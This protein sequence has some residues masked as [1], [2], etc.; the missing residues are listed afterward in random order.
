MWHGLNRLSCWRV[1]WIH[2]Q[3][4]LVWPASHQNV[5][6]LRI[7]IDLTDHAEGFSVDLDQCS[8]FMGG[9]VAPGAEQ[10][11]GEFNF[12]VAMYESTIVSFCAI[13]FSP[14]AWVEPH[15]KLFVVVAKVFI[16]VEWNV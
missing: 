7:R 4:L 13:L 11:F 14:V 6:L 8:C 3:P 5:Q 12:L 16:F 1:E 2:G 15:R 10:S 9:F